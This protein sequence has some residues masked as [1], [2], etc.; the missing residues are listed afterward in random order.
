MCFCIFQCIE[1]VFLCPCS[2]QKILSLSLS[3]SV[4]AATLKTNGKRGLCSDC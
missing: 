4:Q 2:V 3:A 1:G